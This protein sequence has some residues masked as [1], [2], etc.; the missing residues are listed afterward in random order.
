[1]TNTV[2]LPVKNNYACYSIEETPSLLLGTLNFIHSALAASGLSLNSSCRAIPL[3]LGPKPTEG[4]TPHYFCLLVSCTNT[5]I[6][7]AQILPLE[8]TDLLDANSQESP[9]SRSPPGVGFQ[10]PPTS[11]CCILS[12]R[13]ETHLFV[14]TCLTETPSETVPFISTFAPLLHRANMI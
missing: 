12:L 7:T 6:S 9:R 5:L 1:M 11:L 4:T 13:T 10:T 2:Q 8:A 3:I 14:G